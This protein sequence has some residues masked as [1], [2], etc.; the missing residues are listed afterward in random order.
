MNTLVSMQDD[1]DYKMVYC[2]THTGQP[3]EQ[4]C[5]NCNAFACA[6]CLY[7]HNTFAHRVMPVEHAVFL[8]KVND[9]AANVMANKPDA[10]KELISVLLLRRASYIRELQGLTNLTV[11]MVSSRDH[12]LGEI[13]RLIDADIKQLEIEYDHL[14]VTS[15]HFLQASK[16]LKNMQ[17]PLSARLSAVAYL[18]R[19]SKQVLENGYAIHLQTTSLFVLETSNGAPS[20]GRII[21]QRICEPSTEISSMSTKMTYTIVRDF[22]GVHEPH[23]VIDVSHAD[24][25]SALTTG[26]VVTFGG[27]IVLKSGSKRD[28]IIVLSSHGRIER[29]IVFADATYCVFAGD[30]EGNNIW[31]YWKSP[32]GTMTLALVDVQTGETK[33]ERKKGLA[34]NLNRDDDIVGLTVSTDG[35]TIYLLTQFGYFLHFNRKGKRLLSLCSSDDEDDTIFH[36]E[37]F[38]GEFIATKTHLLVTDG[39]SGFGSFSPSSGELLSFEN[40]ESLYGK[41]LGSNIGCMSYDRFAD[42]FAYNRSIDTNSKR[43]FCDIVLRSAHPVEEDNQL[44]ASFCGLPIKTDNA[45][46]RATSREFRE[47]LASARGDHHKPEYN[48][49][50]EDMSDPMPPL[51]AHIKGNFLN[52]TETGIWAIAFNSNSEL[53]VLCRQGEKSLIAIY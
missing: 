38:L 10:V 16:I 1:L 20:L 30:A 8:A 31:V 15:E 51:H 26:M 29:E 13:T 48:S 45:Y 25:L 37:F 11:E 2:T 33:M 21:R 19:V 40:D 7:T 35:E 23:N 17:L 39:S 46:L 9:E 14:L 36:A 47:R 5:I 43:S 53:F 24:V 50:D 42:I 49:D 52:R 34:K 44:L 27:L 18:L 12:L 22:S 41:F 28:T 6:V 4:Y 3:A 32:Q